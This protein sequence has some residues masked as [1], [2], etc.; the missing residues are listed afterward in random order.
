[1][2]KYFPVKSTKKT[3][4]ISY[5]SLRTHTLLIYANL[6]QDGIVSSHMQ[7]LHTGNVSRRSAD[8]ISSNCARSSLSPAIDHQPFI[9]SARKCV[10]L[11]LFC[12]IRLYLCGQR[13]T[14]I[15][16]NIIRRG[17]VLENS[18]IISYNCSYPQVELR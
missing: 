6:R 4:V 7:L 9:T 15:T 13:C 2:K 3:Q 12:S 17:P 1:M 5:T 10:I 16:N 14:G 11:D 8:T 18:S